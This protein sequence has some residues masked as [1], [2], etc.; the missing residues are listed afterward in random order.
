MSQNVTLPARISAAQS[1]APGS[2]PS[3]RGSQAV[4]TGVQMLEVHPQNCHFCHF[5]GSSA[6]LPVGTARSARRCN[7]VRSDMIRARPGHPK[8]EWVWVHRKLPHQFPLIVH[9]LRLSAE[10][11]LKDEGER[12]KDESDCESAKTKPP[13]QNARR[14]AEGEVRKDE[15][16]RG[17]FELVLE[18]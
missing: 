6:R 2:R 11:F 7:I 9:Y 8:T 15:V 18:K 12:R 1:R 4:Y 16:R 10:C 14:K 13:G 17:P 5:S 3:R